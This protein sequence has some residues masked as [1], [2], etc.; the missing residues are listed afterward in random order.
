M[1]MPWW[2]LL[3]FS[4]TNNRI[5]WF[6]VFEK[7]R[8]K[9]VGSKLLECALN[10]LEK[11]KEITVETFQADY[12]PGIPARH[13]YNKFKFE[14]SDNTAVEGE[15]NPR[16]IMIKLPEKTAKKGQSFHYIYRRYMEWSRPEKCP[17]C[18]EEPGPSDIVTIKELEH[19]LSV[20]CGWGRFS[21]QG[22]PG[23]CGP[24]RDREICIISR[25]YT[26]ELFPAKRPG[27]TGDL[28]V[29]WRFVMI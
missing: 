5:S 1:I 18:Q 16:C 8:K 3:G 10:Q 20:L 23:L 13:L 11:S 28:E 14:D 27:F 26:H 4:L 29:F 15:G 17:V 22:S 25:T 21:V 24:G 19:A 2:V 7:Y 12:K 6:A 9:G